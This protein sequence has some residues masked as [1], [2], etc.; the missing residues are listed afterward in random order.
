[1]YSS[2]GTNNCSANLAPKIRQVS[3]NVQ[4][5][6]MYRKKYF[7]LSDSLDSLMFFYGGVH[8]LLLFVL[9]FYEE[10]IK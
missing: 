10:A 1:M 6:Q 5:L 7:F 9:N 4:E 2:L 3:K 8:I